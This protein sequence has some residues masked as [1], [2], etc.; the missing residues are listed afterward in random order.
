MRRVLDII[1]FLYVFNM[2]FEHCFVHPSRA[3]LTWISF[4]N[5]MKYENV[6]INRYNCC[7]QT[8][9]Q[10]FYYLS[11][12]PC[13]FT[14]INVTVMTLTLDFLY[15][16]TA[17]YRKYIATCSRCAS[18]VEIRGYAYLTSYLQCQHQQAPPAALVCGSQCDLVHTND[19]NRHRLCLGWFVPCVGL[20]NF[21]A[22]LPPG[23]RCLI[24]HLCTGINYFNRS[25][26]EFV[27]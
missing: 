15:P 6:Y 19:T 17:V 16:A 7:Y 21:T 3:N 20:R 25:Y 11:S 26:C 5:E 2:G 22:A 8:V 24:W 23:D 10:R 9:R 4:H 13:L 27:C 18:V 14:A 12:D 1:L